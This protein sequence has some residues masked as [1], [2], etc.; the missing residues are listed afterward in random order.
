MHTVLK[1][2]IGSDKVLDGELYELLTAKKFTI[3]DLNELDEKIG[4]RTINHWSEKGYLISTARQGEWRKFSF[5]EYIWILFLNELRE[6]NVSHKEILSTLF[7]NWGLSAIM[8]DEIGQKG[9]HDL[10]KSEFEV[11]LKKIDK[12]EVLN[13]FF[14]LLNAVISFKTP[15]SIRFF[16]KDNPLVIYGNPAYHKFTF[17]LSIADYKKIVDISNFESSVTISIDGLIKEYITRKDLENIADVNLLADE[18]IQILN[19]IKNGELKEITFTLEN[20]EF[21]KFKPNI[22]A[23]NP[24]VFKKVKQ[25]FLTD[26][27]GYEFITNSGK[28]FKMKRKRFNT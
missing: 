17:N 21:V 4:Y 12:E 15:I 18:E 25:I 14:L 19:Q 13:Y 2:H 10:K 26:Y 24:N 27:E 7:I 16:K 9:V 23:S 11:I 28:E 1:D 8:K 20:G 3:K 6:M 5:I 22:G